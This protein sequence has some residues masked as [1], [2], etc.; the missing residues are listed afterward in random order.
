M[1]MPHSLA[2]MFS[3]VDDNPVA[4]FEIFLLGYF[5]GCDQKLSQYGFMMLLSL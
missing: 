4:F 2:S 1:D 3:I 5:R